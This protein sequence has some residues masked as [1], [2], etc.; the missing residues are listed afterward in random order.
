VQKTLKA[1]VAFEGVGLHSGKPARMVLKPAPA[2]H[3]ICFKRTDIALG[4]NLVP[5]RWD[6]VERSPLC[7]KLVNKAGVKVS[8]VEHIMAA[9]AGCGVHNALV[10]IDGEEV[11]IA[12]GSSVEFVRAIMKQGVRRQEAP[13]EAWEVVEPVTVEKDGAKATL[14]PAGRFKIEFHI[15]FAEEA[16]GRQ[17]RTLDM[18][19]GAFARELCDSRTFCRRADVEGMQAAGLA[20]GGV[21]GENAVVFDGSD[22]Q[23]GAGLRHADE[24]VRHKMLDALGDLALAGAPIIGHYVGDK[25][26]HALTN[27]LLRAAFSQP[28]ALRRVTCDARMLS[29]LPGEGLVWSEIPA[30]SQVA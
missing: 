10:E 26:G 15:D 22:V 17:S 27:T 9:L 24:P 13:V 25:A 6:L 29:N 1:T 14:L 3:G 2:G 8:T 23:S 12:D 18:R 20:L 28:G 30:A 4:D 11:P 19:N 16:I 7:T 21:P 5:A